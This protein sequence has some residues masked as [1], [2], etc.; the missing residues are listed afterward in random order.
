MR[1]A[2]INNKI[3]NRPTSKMIKS[4][5]KVTWQMARDWFNGRNVD[6]CRPF[7]EADSDKWA[8]MMLTNT[9]YPELTPPLIFSDDEVYGEALGDGQHRMRA[10]WKAKKTY[11]Y[12]VVRHAPVDLI[13]V[14]DTG[15]P[16]TAPDVL[17]MHGYHNT[18]VLAGAARFAYRWEA[19]IYHQVGYRLVKPSHMQLLAFVR[20]NK[21]L[22]QAVKR[23]RDMYMKHRV[24]RPVVASFAYWL[25]NRVDGHNAES[26]VSAWL[27]RSNLFD[28]HP[29]LWLDEKLANIIDKRNR[30]NRSY[31]A[32][33]ALAHA[34]VAWNYF[35]N[36]EP[37]QGSI[38]PK[39]GWNQEN[40]PIP[41]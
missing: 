37:I 24:I 3:D 12:T 21:D 11:T 34:I 20:E 41:R 23:G 31:I 28:N 10:Q 25:F 32:I 6:I 36:D 14:V 39:G 29:I 38:V 27:A 4:E 8:G 18:L 15:T 7:R 2:S 1:V 26:F 19:G 22:H 17:K 16:R 30:A 9:W 13:D 5:E 33:E 35:R 40:F